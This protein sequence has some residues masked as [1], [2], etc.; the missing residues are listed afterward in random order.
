MQYPAGAAPSNRGHGVCLRVDRLLEM[1]Q[2]EGGALR[3]RIG[4]GGE[5]GRLPN[6]AGNRQVRVESERMA[7]NTEY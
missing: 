7:V 6:A 4:V 1:T 5:Q 3:L 2:A